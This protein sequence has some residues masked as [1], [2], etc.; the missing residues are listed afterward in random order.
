M[1][2]FFIM[3][4]LSVYF[5]M[6]YSL[7][8]YRIVP[9]SSII[10]FTDMTMSALAYSLVA[11]LGAFLGIYFGKKWWQIIYVDK[12][13]YFDKADSRALKGRRIKKNS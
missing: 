8:Y 1:M 13:Y 4:S 5:C 6:I 7:V 2:I 10:S 9:I 3:V 11:I 12:V